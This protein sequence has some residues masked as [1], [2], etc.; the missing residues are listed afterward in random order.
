MA[1]HSSILARTAHGVTKSPIRL[2]T[3]VFCSP[4]LRL[5]AWGLPDGEPGATPRVSCPQ[6]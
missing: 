1:A 3:A 6:P 2:S 5:Q 4:K